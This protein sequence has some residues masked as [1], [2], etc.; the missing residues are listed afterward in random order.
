MKVFARALTDDLG[1]LPLLREAMSLAYGFYF[2]RAS[3]YRRLFKGVY[4]DF[5]G[6]T[7]AVPPGRVIG[8]DNEASAQRLVHER[9]MIFPSDYPVMFWLSRLLDGTRSVF[10]WGGN[11]GISYLA[12]RTYLRYPEGLTWIVKDVP[13]VVAVGRKIAAHE[14]A[15]NLLFTTDFKALENADILLAAGSLQFIDNP[16]APLRAASVRPRHVLLNKVPVYD[17]PSAATLQNMG[18]AF[19]PNHLFS[20]AE[21]VGNFESLGYGLV[22]AWS[23]PGLGCYIPFHPAHSIEAYSGFYFI[24]S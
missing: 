19:V 24:R 13:A 9:H 3:G 1:R 16:Y 12:Y 14:A 21:V 20:R 7:G 4:P 17:R 10:D 15:P 11:V 5:A 2:S 18:T 6:A 8:Y 22:D 23:N